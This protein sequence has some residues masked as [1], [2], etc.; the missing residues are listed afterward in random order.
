MICYSWRRLAFIKTRRGTASRLRQLSS[1]V[2]HS[3]FTLL[4]LLALLALLTLHISLISLS[5]FHFYH[6]FRLESNVRARFSRSATVI[7]LYGHNTAWNGRA[8]SCATSSH[9]PIFSCYAALCNLE[10]SVLCA[11]S[12]HTRHERRMPTLIKGVCSNYG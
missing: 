1:E 3:S 9:L 11:Y 2:F 7:A 10:L 8:A 12:Y 6:S 4:T 5:S